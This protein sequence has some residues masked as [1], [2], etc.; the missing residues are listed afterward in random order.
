MFTCFLCVCATWEMRESKTPCK[1]PLDLSANSCTLNASQM[2]VGVNLQSDQRPWTCS[3]H[4]IILTSGLHYSRLLRK[5][6]T[7]FVIKICSKDCT[8]RR[9]CGEGKSEVRWNFPSVGIHRPKTDQTLRRKCPG[10]QI[11]SH[12]SYE[13]FCISD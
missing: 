5:S 9:L 8:Q 12:S 2:L 7:C 1:A 4:C 10:K 13:K 11:W 3:Q 6:Y